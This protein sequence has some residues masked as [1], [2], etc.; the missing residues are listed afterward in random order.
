VAIGLG[1]GVVRSTHLFRALCSFWARL[2]ALCTVY[3]RIRVRSVRFAKCTCRAVSSLFR[4]VTKSAPLHALRKMVR[5][6]IPASPGIPSVS[7]GGRPSNGFGLVFL[8]EGGRGL[9][10]S[11]SRQYSAGQPSF[12]LRGDLRHGVERCITNLI[13]YIPYSCTSSE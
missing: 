10:C 6:D 7:I 8:L 11:P 1:L 5:R 13:F 4:C 12:G 3:I 2:V 9:G